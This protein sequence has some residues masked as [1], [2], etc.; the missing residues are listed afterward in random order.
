MKRVLVK[1][2]SIYAEKMGR[3]KILE[4]DDNTTI[5]K[6]REIIVRELG[7]VSVKPLIFV[8]YRFPRE[9]QIIN[10]GDEILVV[11]PFAGG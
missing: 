9:G 4:I 10:D 6:L 5:E 1:F 2:I 7:E 3:E 11:P 8:N